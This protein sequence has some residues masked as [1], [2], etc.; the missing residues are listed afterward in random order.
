MVST[1]ANID[2]VFRKGLKDFEVLPP[3]E[4][5]NFIRPVIRKKQQPYII[6]RSAAFVAVL[7]SISFLVYRWSREISTGSENPVLAL[8]EES[9]ATVNYPAISGS[10]QIDESRIPGIEVIQKDLTTDQ[11]FISVMPDNE[12]VTQ[13]NIAFLPEANNLL[14]DSRVLFHKP[15]LAILSNQ[16]YNNRSFEYLDEKNFSSDD[17]KE[18]TNRWSVAA[19]ASPTYYPR[20]KSGDDELTKQIM[21]S[22]QSQV[23]YSGGVAFSYMISKKL[24][25]QSGLYYSSV[26]QEV[27]GINSFLGFQKYDYTKG[28]HNFE[29]LTSSGTI[30]TSNMDVFLLDRAGERVLTRYSNDI[31]DPVKSNLQYL[32][33][34]LH[35]SFSYIEMPVILRYKVVDRTLDVNVIGGLSYNLLVNNSVYTMIDGGRYTVGKTDG[36]NPM[37]FSSSI[38]MGMEYNLS[39]K[40]SL[41]FEPTFRYFLNPFSGIPNVKIHPYSIGVFSGLSYKF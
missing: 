3:S 16:S 31:F 19:M 18:K 6:L 41:N 38:G 33:N 28:D 24:S 36:L 37:M 1:G 32:N 40:I 15:G 11:P 8:N 26:G 30:Y 23:S 35:Q 17:I 2:L 29:V 22:E 13:T 34:S 27:N 10:T 7:L 4:V 25:I 39:E 9:I 5:W 14:T 12:G 21:A 20:F